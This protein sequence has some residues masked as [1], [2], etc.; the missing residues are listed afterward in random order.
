MHLDVALMASTI[1]DGLLCPTGYGTTAAATCLGA[2]TER[3]ISSIFA[4]TNTQMSRGDHRGV[5]NALIQG[6][7]KKKPQAFDFMPM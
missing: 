2:R 4:Y 1:V 6:Q 7:F 5:K 3:T